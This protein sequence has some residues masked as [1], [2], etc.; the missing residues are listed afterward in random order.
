LHLF[1]YFSY[2]LLGR[3]AED[4]SPR[5]VG[6]KRG[7]HLTCYIRQHIREVHASLMPRRGT[8]L[9][10]HLSGVVGVCRPTAF[11]WGLCGNS[12]R[13]QNV[14]LRGAGTMHPVTSPREGGWGKE[15]RWGF[16]V[17]ILFPHRL[18]W[19]G[20]EPPPYVFRHLSFVPRWHR[21]YRAVG[22]IAF[23]PPPF[24]LC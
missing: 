10:S 21:S 8:M 3:Y 20:G 13:F 9:L 12:H 4:R 11:S 22:V 14:F 2:T 16:L 19:K 15:G 17:P 23:P 1:M 18:M 24:S 7:G 5:K 6:I